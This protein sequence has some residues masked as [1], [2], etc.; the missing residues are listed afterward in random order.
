MAT[1]AGGTHSVFLFTY[2]R[3]PTIKSGFIRE[4]R[5]IECES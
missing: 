4:F 3:K 2:W 1:L 5:Q